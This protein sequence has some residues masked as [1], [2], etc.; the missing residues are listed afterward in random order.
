[1]LIADLHCAVSVGKCNN[2]ANSI[3]QSLSDC[4]TGFLLIDKLYSIYK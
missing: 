4:Y 2:Q 1:M 3:K